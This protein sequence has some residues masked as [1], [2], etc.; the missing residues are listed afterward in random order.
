M[1]KKYR[2]ATQRAV[3]LLHM[4]GGMGFDRKNVHLGGTEHELDASDGCV[5]C[6]PGT[7][8]RFVETSEYEHDLGKYG[9]YKGHSGYI[10]ADEFSNDASSVNDYQTQARKYDYFKNKNIVL[11]HKGCSRCEGKGE[12]QD[13][14]GQSSCKT[15]S[16]AGLEDTPLDRVLAHVKEFIGVCSEGE[17]ALVHHTIH[18]QMVM[19]V[20]TP[21]MLI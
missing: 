17:L 6:T 5:Q 11:Q 9:R 10:V 7:Y 8:S 19:I 13:E 15:C 1:V 4:P 12:Y 20:T 18:P 2:M 21:T 3:L 16:D 14:F